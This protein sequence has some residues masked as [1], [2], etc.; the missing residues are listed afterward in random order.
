MTETVYRDPL[1]A[2]FLIN[3]KAELTDSLT[4]PGLAAKRIIEIATEI[5]KLETRL[6]R[7]A[8]PIKTRTKK[9]ETPLEFP[10][11]LPEEEP[12]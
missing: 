7:L 12:A 11:T 6:T 3:R 2:D 9:V 4:T 10:E 8:A 1:F 5:N